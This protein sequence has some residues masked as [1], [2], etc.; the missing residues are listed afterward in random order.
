MG[1]TFLNTLRT[2]DLSE[3]GTRY[4]RSFAP[5]HHIRNRPARAGGG[6]TLQ[7]GC[8]FKTPMSNPNQ[9]EAG[10]RSRPQSTR[11]ALRKPPASHPPVD[12]VHFLPVS[13][14]LQNRLQGIGFVCSKSIFAH[15]PADASRTARAFRSPVL[16][17][18][19][20]SLP[21]QSSP[22]ARLGRPVDPARSEPAA[23][24]PAAGP[25]TRES[26][27]TPYFTDTT[28]SFVQLY[29]RPNRAATCTKVHNHA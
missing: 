13:K 20:R 9:L 26:T 8:V 10:S 11:T 17:R 7:N 18:G 25:S 15:D 16:S 29:T 21:K 3:G 28:G 27:P 4:W 12:P 2:V 22:A 5:R 14:T 24:R 19:H 1:T 6:Q 23:T